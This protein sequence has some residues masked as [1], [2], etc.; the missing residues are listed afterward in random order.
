[1]IAIAFAARRSSSD[2]KAA[3]AAA[4][5]DQFKKAAEEAKDRV[6]E[7]GEEWEAAGDIDSGDGGVPIAIAK[8]ETYQPVGFG[9]YRGS[10]GKGNTGQQPLKMN[11]AARKAMADKEAKRAREKEEAALVKKG[12]GR[13]GAVTPDGEPGGWNYLGGPPVKQENGKQGLQ[14]GGVKVEA[15]E[16]KREKKVLSVDELTPRFQN[17]LKVMNVDDEE[18]EGQGGVKL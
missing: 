1:M 2:R 8:A 17:R 18:G 7:E 9:V 15:N 14:D 10:A 4:R 16:A 3:T 5:A 12:P 6:K 11:A 13:E